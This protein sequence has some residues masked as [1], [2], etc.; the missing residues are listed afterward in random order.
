VT[1]IYSPDPDTSVDDADSAATTDG[2]SISDDY[3]APFQAIDLNRPGLAPFGGDSPGWSGAQPADPMAA[4]LGRI[5]Y[6]MAMG[7]DPDDLHPDDQFYG[8][9]IGQTMQPQP[10]LP[11]G[12]LGMGLDY[13]R[14]TAQLGAPVQ[15]DQDPSS[16]GDSYIPAPQPVTP[17]DLNTAIPDTSF[18]PSRSQSG[19]Q[20]LMNIDGL[21]LERGQNA[22]PRFDGLIANKVTDFFNSMRDQ[23]IPA[24][25]RS[26]LRTEAGQRA[27]QGNKNG[28]AQ[29]GRSLHQAGLAFDINWEKLTPSQQV[30]A[31]STAAGLGLK[32]GG[33]FRNNYDAEHFYVDPFPNIDA[34][35][36]Y[37]RN[38][39]QTAPR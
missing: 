22:L 8:R 9:F 17:P 14:S 13:L 19:P 2:P 4:R 10:P 12:P 6:H 31:R 5:T 30:A 28:G 29:A 34:R 18:Q 11:P 35:Q 25:L 1:D 39:Q 21:P 15:A 26:G 32:W 3:T 24:E 38:L 33:A 23:G 27:V 36:A 16:G 20:G 7:G 37:I